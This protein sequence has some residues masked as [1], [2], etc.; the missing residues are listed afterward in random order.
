[1]SGKGVRKLLGRGGASTRHHRHAAPGT[2]RAELRPGGRKG[3]KGLLEGRS[4]LIG[5]ALHLLGG[6]SQLVARLLVGARG[7][8]HLA[9]VVLK[10]VVDA[11]RGGGDAAHVG[12]AHLAHG[13][14]GHL[15]GVELGERRLPRG[16]ARGPG[17]AGDGMQRAARA[18]L[19]AGPTSVG[20]EPGSLHLR[21]VRRQLGQLDADPAVGQLRVVAALHL[22][23]RVLVE[24]QPAG[25]VRDS[26]DA[27][28]F[29]RLD[30]GPV[31][32]VAPRP[33]QRRPEGPAAGGGVVGVER[34]RER[35]HRVGA[36]PHAHGVA[37]AVGKPALPLGG[38]GLL[39]R[40]LGLVGGL[41][42]LGGGLLDLTD[43]DVGLEGG[44]VALRLLGEADGGARVVDVVGVV[45]L[46]HGKGAGGD[47]K[48]QGGLDGLEPLR[49]RCRE[50]RARLHDVHA[51]TYGR[52]ACRREPRHRGDHEASGKRHDARK[53]QREHAGVKRRGDGRVGADHVGAGQGARVCHR[54]DVGRAVLHPG[55][56]DERAGER[57]RHEQ[58]AGH[59]NGGVAAVLAHEGADS[60]LKRAVKPSLVVTPISRPNHRSLPSAMR[61]ERRRSPR[62]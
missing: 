48:R 23:C 4:P 31:R 49:G 33:Q 53:A 20:I 28:A 29:G 44:E 11:R 59:G 13:A 24:R 18:L 22:G 2:R 54:L 15:T 21:D 51:C 1:M 56:R 47:G 52:S 25:R 8:R 16:G 60:E 45:G 61:G 6:V 3:L 36:L 37:A 30:G 46:H 55:Q 43:G 62:P 12:G 57:K 32:V 9:P 5:K 17:A 34:R 58:G 40:L 7:L 35:G 26:V 38:V 42:Q 14:A 50:A 10:A 19:R 27:H 39:L 41:L